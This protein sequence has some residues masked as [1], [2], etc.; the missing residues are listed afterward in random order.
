MKENILDSLVSTY[1]GVNLYDFDNNIQLNWYPKR[2][3]KSAPNA[4]SMLELG[5]GH[6]LSTNLFSAHFDRYVVVDASKAVIDNFHRKFPETK[7]EV[8]EKFF[9]EFQSDEKFDVVMLGFVL[10]HVDDPVLIID[11]YKKFLA[12]GGKIFIT[13]PN[14]EV[15]N[16]RLGNVAGLLPDM[17][18]LSEH[19]HMAGH[20]RYYSVQSLTEDIEK[21]GCS[22]VK[23]EGIYLKPF[24][25]KQMISLEFDDSIIEALCTVGVDYPELCCGILGEITV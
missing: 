3:I 12:P 17:L 6:G 2:V 1:E 9:E 10:E 19:D 16:R 7:I 24:T 21:A 5:L 13:V 15:L 20:K 11:L 25:T 23:F 4:K 22:V 14:S 8:V 18:E